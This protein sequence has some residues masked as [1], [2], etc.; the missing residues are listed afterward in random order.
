VVL[1]PA[2]EWLRS[3]LDDAVGHHRRYT[4]ASLTAAVPPALRCERLEYLDS[5]GMFLSCANRWLL[6]RSVPSRA[7]VRFW[8]RAVVPVSRLVDPLLGRSVGKSVLGI[9]RRP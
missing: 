6:R 4:R 7:Q 9:W 2:H 8:D 1:A 5:M 3:P